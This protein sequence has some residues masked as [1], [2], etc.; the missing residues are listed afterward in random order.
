MKIAKKL[1]KQALNEQRKYHNNDQY[2]QLKFTPSNEQLKL[3]QENYE[4]R[5]VLYSNRVD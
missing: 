3:I 1:Y 2:N 4:N 5:R